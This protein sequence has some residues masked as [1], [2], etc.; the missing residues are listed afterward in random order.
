[1]FIVFSICI[2]NDWCTNEYGY[3][4]WQGDR[5]LG[6]LGEEMVYTFH[7]NPFA[8]GDK[9]I[10]IALNPQCFFVCLFVFRIKNPQIGHIG[11]SI[12]SAMGQSVD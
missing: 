4:V 10:K 7:N 8:L 5:Y 6:C 11:L 12:A 2:W 9:P 1:M 3:Q